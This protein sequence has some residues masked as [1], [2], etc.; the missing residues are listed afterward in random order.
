LDGK[1]ALYT[2]TSTIL[3]R[4]TLRGR[5][6]VAPPISLPKPFTCAVMVS[7]ISTNDGGVYKPYFFMK[8]KQTDTGND[9]QK[10]TYANEHLPTQ[11][12]THQPNPQPTPRT[13]PRQL[14]TVNQASTEFFFR[15]SLGFLLSD[16]E[17]KKELHGE[18]K[19]FTF[20]LFLCVSQ[21]TF[22]FFSLFSV[23]F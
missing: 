14:K 19:Q 21:F 13:T 12:N 4:G 9:L 1:A 5:D 20:S 22:S 23:Y 17:R 2:Y 6:P 15:S 8:R 3:F 7:S 10:P 18:S 11:H 16:E